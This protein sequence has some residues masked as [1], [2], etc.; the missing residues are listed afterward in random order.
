M[1]QDALRDMR[2][3]IL[4]T[5]TWRFGEFVFASGEEANNKLDAEALVEH[6]S[7]YV[8]VLSE[9]GR[10]ARQWEPKALVGVPR[11]G[12]RLASDLGLMLNLPVI[13]LEKEDTTPGRKTFRY[14]DERDKHLAAT[15]GPIVAL[16]DVT[17]EMTSLDGMLQLP[18][19]REHV[20]A[21]SAIWRR[22]RVE[23]EREL[24][25]PITWLIEE[26]LPN[27]IEAD[28][29]FYQEYGLFAVGRPQPETVTAD[30]V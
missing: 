29:P 28:H 25:V 23:T 2:H 5:G 13:E 9:L 20:V 3:Q 19:L 12:Q 22:G 8:Y 6:T 4:S 11:G 26:P 16:E 15:A 21:V 17:S 18:E 7:Q 14:A 10:I 1:N 24:G 27:V 30:S